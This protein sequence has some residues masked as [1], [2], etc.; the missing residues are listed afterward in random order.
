M[1]ARYRVAS[2]TDDKFIFESHTDNVF[3][4]VA[5]KQGSIAEKDELIVNSFTHKYFF[6][7]DM[8]VR[9]YLFLFLIPLYPVFFAELIR[10]EKINCFNG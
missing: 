6:S 10:L 7:L 2:I 5:K 4:K 9:L 1:K 3:K 8:Y